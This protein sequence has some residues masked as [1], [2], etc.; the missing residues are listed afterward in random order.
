[1]KT[2][3]PFGSHGDLHWGMGNGEGEEESIPEGASSP[4]LSFRVSLDVKRGG[5]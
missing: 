5:Q 2:P 4:E 3:W 1:M